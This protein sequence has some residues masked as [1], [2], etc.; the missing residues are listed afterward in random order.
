MAEEIRIEIGANAA[1]F[2]AELQKAE[3]ELRQFNAA[4]KKTTDIKE[5]DKLNEQIKQTQQTIGGLNKSM[6]SVKPSTNAASG[7]V[8]NL[9]RIV[10]DSAYG[11]IGIA[12]NIQPFIDS[13][14]YAKKEAQA[15]GT[16]LGK[17]LLSVLTGAGGLSLGFAAV[18]TAIT[19]AQIGFSAWTKGSQKAKEAADEYRKSL[20]EVIGTLSKEKT[21]VDTIIYALNN[22]KL[23]R[24]QRTEAIKQLQQIAPQYFATLNSEKSTI[25]D[26]NTS[27]QKYN[28]NLIKSL[29]L[30]LKQKDLEDIQKKILDLQQKGLDVGAK[31]LYQNGKRIKVIQSSAQSYGEEIKGLTEYQKIKEG[32]LGLNQEEYDQLKNLQIQRE[33][34]IKIIAEGNGA[35]IFDKSGIK[36]IETVDD[37]LKKLNKDLK[38]QQDISIVFD[39][40][41]IQKQL[42]LVNQAIIDLITK[43]NLSPDDKRII[44][45]QLQAVDLKA[46]LAALNMQAKRDNVK[47]LVPLK[48]DYGKELQYIP[49]IAKKIKPINIPVNIQSDIGA[50]GGK[51]IDP[52]IL[53]RF[54]TSSKQ[55]FA[56][57][58]AD[59]K[60][61]SQDLDNAA[62][63]FLTDAATNIATKFGEA[64]GAALT[65]GN[66]GEVFKG[67]FELIASGIESLGK[68]L[69][70]IG[71][72]AIIAQQALAQLLANPFA[73]IA[74][75]IALVA[76]GAAVKNLTNK[77]A[78]AT[79]TNYAPGGM[80]LVG[81]RGP[82]LVNLPRGSQVIPAG[83]TAAMLG[84][85]GQ[86]VEVFG[87]L[88]GQDIYFSNKKYG[89]TYGRTT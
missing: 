85:M 87:M 38:D 51:V 26:I 77:S 31:D 82:E 70:Q 5:L 53:E 28:D 20:D 23:T 65:G 7:A 43:F 68:Q 50:L 27:Y 89:Q 75:G 64:L 25:D 21:N 78:F 12:N 60:K 62:T 8:L 29:N 76:L 22:E 9:S 35:K 41:T 3:N 6:Q 34:L 11:F 19:F 52:K 67:V 54:R 10:S 72:L 37:L 56:D 71:F 44:K 49:D 4:L 55:S 84:G 74:V 36:D 45:L 80:A 69:I 30:K 48:L 18:T 42:E 33:N 66:F 73:A 58:V 61:F 81:E 40:P 47:L 63:T 15:T 13:L 83:R 1:P 46:E 14:G 39:I 17:N 24:Q 2:N 32:V 16:S 86:Q 59:F 88:R 79:G 57:L